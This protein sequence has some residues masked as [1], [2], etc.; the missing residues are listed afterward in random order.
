MYGVPLANST[1]HIVIEEEL[2]A[3]T[4]GKKYL[5]RKNM[6]ETDYG[7]KKLIKMAFY[8]S[9]IPH[10][11]IVQVQAAQRIVIPRPICE[12]EDIRQGEYLDVTIRKLLPAKKK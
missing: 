9:T 4:A 12:I 6:E 2:T 7:V 5:S 3:Q 8:T 11:F 10:N 1:E